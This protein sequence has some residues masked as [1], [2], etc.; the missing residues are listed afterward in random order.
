MKIKKLTLCLLVI[1]STL[2]MSCSSSE[3][4]ELT[5]YINRIKSRPIKPIEPIPEVKP[6]PKFAYPETDSRRSPFKPMVIERQSD[7]FAPNTN[8]PKQP[9]EAF[10]L[11]ALK[12]V[13]VLKQGPMVWALISQP[14]NVVSRI[15]PGDYMGKNY[16]QVIS[17]KDKALKL[18]E[19]V[20][21]NGKWEKKEI[22][23]YL[24]VPD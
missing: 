24:R 9:L 6:F 19:T 14:D 22:T 13:G 5:R 3:D 20:Q 7:Q 12:F 8:R 2:L 16:G 4:S 11:D 15:K 10:P 17:I 21:V 18:V 23:L 1:I